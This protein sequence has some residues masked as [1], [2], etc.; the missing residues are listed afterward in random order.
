MTTPATTEGDALAMSARTISLLGVVVGAVWLAIGIAML[1]WPDATLKVIAVLF[2]LQL[3]IGGILRMVSGLFS[4]LEGWVRAVYVLIGVIMLLAGIACLRTPALSIA[5]ILLLTAIGWLVDGIAMV[6]AGTRRREGRWALLGFG[7]VA[8]V[9]AIILLVAPVES[10]S[11]LLV[12]GGWLLVILGLVAL[13]AGILGM[14]E[15][16]RLSHAGGAGGAVAGTA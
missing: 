13:V 11:A 3:V 4:E 5:V 6:V 2:G 8:I 12:L 10:V 1:A 15:V 9:A 16:S 7:A 14:R